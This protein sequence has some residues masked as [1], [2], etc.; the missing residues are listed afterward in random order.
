MSF[1]EQPEKENT[2]TISFAIGSKGIKYLGNNQG[3]ERFVQGKLQDNA[4]RN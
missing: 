2:K 1:N 3:G 4:E